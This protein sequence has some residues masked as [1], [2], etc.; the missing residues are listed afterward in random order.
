MKRW[1]KNSLW[2]IF[3]I[4]V[5]VLMSLVKTSQSERAVGIPEVNIEVFEDMIFLSEA[6]VISRLKDKHYIGG[7]KVYSDMELEKIEQ[8][9]EGMP[10]VK[11]VQVY[12]YLSGIWKIEMSL[13]QPIARIFNQDG[14]SCYLDQ[15]GTLMPLSSNYTAHVVTVDGNIN[16]TDY[17]K[18]V[19]NIMNN[20]SLITLEI[21][22][23]LYE[24]SNYVCNDE[25]LSAQITH[26]HIN[27]YD[28]FEFIPRV[29]DQRIMFGDA[30]FAAGKFK[31]LEYFY[32]EGMSRAGWDLY[33]TISVMYKGQVVCSKRN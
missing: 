18:S 4:V 31:K 27:N 23:D 6:D 32:T 30:D 26:I 9:I 14:T 22:D 5:G 15:D 3:L 1:L 10:E 21:L 29:G 8:F 2:V 12:T 19:A 25:Y 17:G 13:R 24:I 33:D 16:E 28:E 20:D 7:E 11:K